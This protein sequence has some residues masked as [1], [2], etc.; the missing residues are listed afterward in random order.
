MGGLK[1]KGS[2]WEEGT[3]TLCTGVAH[4]LLSHELSIFSV[5]SKRIGKSVPGSRP[6]TVN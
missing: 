3:Y 4:S 6:S 1:D 5:Y 2:G